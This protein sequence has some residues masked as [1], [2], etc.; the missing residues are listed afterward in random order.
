[1]EQPTVHRTHYL[2]VEY[3]VRSWLLTVDHKRIALLYLVSVT[4]MFLLG[5]LFAAMIRVELLTPQ[6]DFVQA[7]TYN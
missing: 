3:G 5:S 1:M 2:N 4:I 6:G 7:D